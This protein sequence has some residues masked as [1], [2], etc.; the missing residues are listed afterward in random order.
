M[1]TFR[2]P[3]ESVDPGGTELSPM[4]LECINPT[5]NMYYDESIPSGLYAYT[6]ED[7]DFPRVKRMNGKF[8]P[9]VVVRIPKDQFLTIKRCDKECAELSTGYNGYV[10]N[11]SYASA[12][13]KINSK[14]EDVKCIKPP[15]RENLVFNRKGGG[16][17]KKRKTRR[18]A[19]HSRRKRPTIE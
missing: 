5:T 2:K 8:I 1:A 6:G 13:L 14:W 4:E 9:G 12:R 18:K 16:R 11:G 10:D 15:P 17:A 7:K 19:R 3:I